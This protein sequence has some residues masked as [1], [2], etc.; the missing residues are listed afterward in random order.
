MKSELFGKLEDCVKITDEPKLP[1]YTCFPSQHLKAKYKTEGVYG[2][3]IDIDEGIAASKSKSEM[4]ERLSLENARDENIYME[5]KNCSLDAF[6]R[7]KQVDLDV[8]YITWQLGE[9]IITGADYPVPRQFIYND[10]S[11][12]YEPTLIPERI[13]TGAA[14]NRQ[15]NES[16]VLLCGVMECIERHSCMWFYY[17]GIEFFKLDRLPCEIQSLLDYLKRYRLTC[18]IY[19]LR[20]PHAPIHTFVACTQDLTGIGQPISFGASANLNYRNAIRKALLESIQFRFAC[21]RMIQTSAYPK[22][23]IGLTLV[24][25]QR[26]PNG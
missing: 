12:N 14:A 9:N 8:D 23:I 24:G 20:A 4:L 25:F 2:N 16:D 5:F 15:K 18:D 22:R 11:L 26:L 7:D 17:G 3:A 1:T 6:L 10:D 21:R 13:S 19:A